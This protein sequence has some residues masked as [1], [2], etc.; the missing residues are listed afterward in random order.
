MSSKLVDDGDEVL[1]SPHHLA[2]FFSFSFRIIATPPFGE[3]KKMIKKDVNCVLTPLFP[4][5]FFLLSKNQRQWE[6][7]FPTP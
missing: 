7:E 3:H 6:E 2:L 5:F 4:Y 1:S